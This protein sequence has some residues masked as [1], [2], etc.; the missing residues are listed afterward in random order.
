M[1]WNRERS[2]G[3][4]KLGGEFGHKTDLYL[5]LL[6]HGSILP[7]SRHRYPA[8]GMSSS[9]GAL[10]LLFK[11]FGFISTSGSVFSYD[12]SFLSSSFLFCAFYAS[13]MT[14]GELGSIP[15]CSLVLWLKISYSRRKHV[16]CYSEVINGGK[17]FADEEKKWLSME[18]I[19]LLI[20]KI[21][22]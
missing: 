1:G 18:K 13:L 20:I 3:H 15:L 22:Y 4:T 6:R 5:S 17:E 19:S 21:I 12:T 14:L 7:P 2:G 8:P 11:C 9:C 10:T 16:T